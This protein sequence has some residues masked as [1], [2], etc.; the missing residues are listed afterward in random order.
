M[1]KISLFFKSGSSDKEYHA[2]LEPKGSGFVVN[3]QYGRRGSTLTAGTK[4]TSPVPQDK[5]EAIYDKLVQEKMAKGYTQG[6][7]G[8]PYVGTDK[9]ERATGNTPQLLNPI[10][11][12]EVE[13]YLKNPAWGA[14]EKKDGKHVMVEFDGKE[15][16]ASNRK[17]LKIGIPEPIALAVKGLGSDILLLDGESIGEVYHVFDLLRATVRDVDGHDEVVEFK[18]K[19]YI[20][21]YNILDLLCEDLPPA[22]KLVPLAVTEKEKRDLYARLKKEGREGIVFKKLDAPYVPGRPNSGGNMLKFKFYA[23]ASCVVGPGRAGKRSIGLLLMKGG[24]MVSV[25]NCTVPAN[26]PVPA[27]DSI[28]EIRYLY[29]YPDGSLYQPVLLG[30]RDDIDL[31]ACSV[32]QLKYKAEEPQPPGAPS[33]TR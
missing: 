5:A 25:G 30:V 7:S 15:V 24:D 29:S 26:Q 8:T 19:T 17:G 31:D 13:K 16:T 9:E 20:E 28:V 14:Q 27:E 18:D 21:R 6:E 33:E 22:I 4:T 3:F 2:Q 11:E 23:T 10:E 1:K 12:E 32:K